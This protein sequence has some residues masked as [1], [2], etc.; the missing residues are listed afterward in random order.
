MTV[1]RRRSIRRYPSPAVFRVDI[2]LSNNRLG[3]EAK[4]ASPDFVCNT[5][6]MA[7]LL[8]TACV[9]RGSMSTT[10]QRDSCGWSHL[11]LRFCRWGHRTRKFGYL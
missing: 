2:V 3:R 8:Y 1:G 5:E 9:L 6:P 11:H 10:L 7:F 4:W